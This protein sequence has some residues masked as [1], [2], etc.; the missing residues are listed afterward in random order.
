MAWT[1]DVSD[2]EADAEARGLTFD[3][4]EAGYVCHHIRNALQAAQIE[5]ERAHERLLVLAQTM[6]ARTREDGAS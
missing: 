3:R 1:H 2:P 6:E 5:P 4:D